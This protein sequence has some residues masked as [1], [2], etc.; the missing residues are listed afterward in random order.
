MTEWSDFFGREV[1]IYRATNDQHNRTLYRGSALA[2]KY[3]CPTNKI[4]M[5][6]ARH[7]GID[8]GIFQATAFQLKPV[9]RTGLKCGGYFV[10]L[11]GKHTYRHIYQ[12]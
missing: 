9:G 10:S 4:G 7:R 1:E 6:F 12:Y 5:Y 3:N 2:E 8:T 11:S